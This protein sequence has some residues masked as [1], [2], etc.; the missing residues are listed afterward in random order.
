M[1]PNPVPP[2][3]SFILKDLPSPPTSGSFVEQLKAEKFFHNVM[4]DNAASPASPAPDRLMTNLFL[5]R[6]SP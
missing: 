5:P 4:P 6:L 3:L 1:R 2:D